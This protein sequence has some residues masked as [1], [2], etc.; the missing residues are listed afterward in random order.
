LNLFEYR[1]LKFFFSGVVQPS[2]EDVVEGKA[3]GPGGVGLELEFDDR[4]GVAAGG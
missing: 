2:G 4:V 3:K 1:F